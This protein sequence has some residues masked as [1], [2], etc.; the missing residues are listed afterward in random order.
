MARPPYPGVVLQSLVESTDLSDTDAVTLYEAMLGD[1]CEAVAAS[2]GALLINYA[3]REHLPDSVPEEAEPKTAIADVVADAVPDHD[4]VRYE[5]QVGSSFDAR[6]GNTVTHLL[7]R[8]EADSVHVVEPTV[9]MLT[10]SVVDQ[11]SMKL[12]SSPVVVGPAS[13]GRVHYA[14]FTEPI[15]FEG[16]F[17]APALE[18]LVRRA[19]SEGHDVD[20]IEQLTTVETARDLSTITSLLVARSATGR[21]VPERTLAAL[22]SIDP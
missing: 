1:V 3:P 22:E 9:P 10:R 15:D 20:F 21:A 18:T 6:A 12:R 19:V 8:E 11:T 17:D 16:A 13:E 14:G 4:A 7:D 2:G 5:V